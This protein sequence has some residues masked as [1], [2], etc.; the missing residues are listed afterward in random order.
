MQLCF[1][2]SNMNVSRRPANLAPS[3]TSQDHL[4]EGTFD[5]RSASRWCNLEQS[6]QGD[7]LR[8]SAET[9]KRYIAMHAASVARNGVALQ[10]L[11]ACQK[12]CCQRFAKILPIL[13]QRNFE[14]VDHHVEEFDAGP[15]RACSRQ[16]IAELTFHLLASLD[17]PHQVYEM[18]SAQD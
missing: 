8:C 18:A 11:H 12:K 16:Q 13:C 7:I 4:S 9:A 2:Q 15:R 10:S 6:I 14:R 17:S 1:L 3:S 5:L